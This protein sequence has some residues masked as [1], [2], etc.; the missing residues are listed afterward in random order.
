MGLG[1]GSAAAQWMNLAAPHPLCSVRLLVCEESRLGT[2]LLISELVPSRPPLGGLVP[3]FLR[4]LPHNR[5]CQ[6]AEGGRQASLWK[7]KSR[8]RA[9]HCPVLVNPG[10]R[11]GPR[12][13]G[14][15]VLRVSSHIGT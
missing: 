7:T 6:D 3:F 1:R 5:F 4:K 15:R 8:R 14:G 9:D 2:S 11:Y 12:L 13:F 10:T